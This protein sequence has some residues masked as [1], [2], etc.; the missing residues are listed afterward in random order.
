MTLVIRI[1]SINSSSSFHQDLS[2][3]ENQDV[4]EN[5]NFDRFLNQSAGVDFSTDFGLGEDTNL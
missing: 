5:F 4:L 2:T 1:W 3:L